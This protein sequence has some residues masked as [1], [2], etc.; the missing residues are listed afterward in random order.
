MATRARRISD[1]MFMA[2]AR[3]LADMS[4]TKKDPE[5]NLLPPVTQ[6]REVATAVAIAVAKQAQAEGLTDVPADRI[7]ETVRNRMWSPRY[8]PYKRTG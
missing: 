5:A 7:E 4:P 1:T 3:A 6:L 8:L 2:A